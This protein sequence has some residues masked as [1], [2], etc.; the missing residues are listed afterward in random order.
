MPAPQRLISLI[1]RSLWDPSGCC[2]V[3]FATNALGMGIDVKG[4]S[5]VI[6]YGP[7]S[8]L[9]SY[10]QEIGRAGRDGLQ[11]HASLLYH[12]QQ[13]RHAGESMKG[14]INNTSLC[15]RVVLLSIFDTEPAECL[16]KHTCC[17]VCA[18]MCQCCT[19]GDCPGLDGIEEVER[20]VI[21]SNSASSSLELQPEQRD[22]LEFLLL[23]F[24]IK[25]EAKLRLNEQP[26]YTHSSLLTGVT[27]HLIQVI[28]DR[29]VQLHTVEDIQALTPVFNVEHAQALVAILHETVHGVV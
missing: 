13:L 1:L 10:M 29:A 17:D 9:E 4:L 25:E 3:V 24:K 8:S 27:D 16:P 22:L 15:R 11:S 28:L 18:A 21:A 23:E 19:P 6:H 7:S 14:Y 12:G 20:E 2:R 5:T 26:L